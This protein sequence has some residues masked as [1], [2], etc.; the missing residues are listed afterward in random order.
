MELLTISVGPE[1][2]ADASAE[3]GLIQ[4]GYLRRL[5]SSLYIEVCTVEQPNDF[6]HA[7]RLFITAWWHFV[8]VDE[9]NMNIG[10]VQGLY[11]LNRAYGASYDALKVSVS[12]RDKH[13]LL[14]NTPL[15]N[16]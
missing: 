3:A 13:I 10:Y 4:T 12:W 5:D 16:T 1:D 15:G 2:A 9:G 14:P 8:K 7:K 6:D 11:L